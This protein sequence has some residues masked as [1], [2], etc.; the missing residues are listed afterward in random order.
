M[1][2]WAAG[3]FELCGAWSIGNKKRYS[4]IL[5]A[6]CNVL[7]IIYCLTNDT[8]YGLLIVVVPMFFINIRNFIK[9]GK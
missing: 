1:L 6:I 8:T 4:F 2:D 9:W 7:W 3:I 5:F